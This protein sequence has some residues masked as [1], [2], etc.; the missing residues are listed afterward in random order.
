MEIKQ[1][2]L[3]LKD[4]EELQGSKVV[5]EKKKFMSHIANIVFKIFCL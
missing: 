2:T 4:L 3:S 5:E 1:K